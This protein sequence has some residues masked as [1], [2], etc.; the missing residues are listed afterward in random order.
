VNTRTALFAVVAGLG[1]VALAAGAPLAGEPGAPGVD[2]VFLANEGVYLEGGG[3]AVMIDGC[4][5][6]PYMEYG[7]VPDDV[8]A[9][10]V[11][12]EA[13]F[14]RLDLVLVS[15]NHRDHFQVEPA[16]ELLL[17]RSETRWVVH[18][19]IAAVLESGWARWGDVATRVTAIA[20]EGKVPYKYRGDGLEVEA[21]RLPHGAARTL[22]EN[23]AHVV[24]LGGRT[25]VHVGDAAATAGDLESAGL[26]GRTF[27]VGL[28]PYWF[29]LDDDWKRARQALSGR[30]GT[31]ALHRPPDE[32]PASGPGAPRAFQRALERFRF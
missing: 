1:G 29:W 11:K 25:L 14:T 26:A 3:R 27:D 32:A 30:L 4:V 31:V 6:E 13:P 19:E 22:P 8:W 17:A 7:A 15:H 9:K 5:R 10:L 20:P 18:R 12:G 21:I 28:L 2:V 23:L 16:R 24:H